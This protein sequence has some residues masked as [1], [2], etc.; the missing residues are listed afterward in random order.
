MD[1]FIHL[2]RKAIPSDHCVHIINYFERSLEKIIDN[3]RGYS[4]VVV[5]PNSLHLGNI[6]ADGLDEYKKKHPTLSHTA[7]GTLVPVGYYY[8]SNIQKY[9]P[10]DYYNITHFE[11]GWT[12]DEESNFRVLAWIIYLNTIRHKGGTYWPNQRF[13]SK[14]REGDLYIWPADFTHIHHGIPA[15]KETKYIITGWYN[16]PSPNVLP[17]YFK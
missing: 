13:T 4:R 12:L 10:G 3:K 1:K 6:L 14:P 7:T 11:R 5:N 17:K 16:F 9:S 8:R 2:K 15:P